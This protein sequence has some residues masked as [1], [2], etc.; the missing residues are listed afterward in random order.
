[1]SKRSGR[2]P[3]FPSTNGSL[4]KYGAEDALRVCRSLNAKKL[5]RFAS[6][7]QADDRLGLI[8][9]P[10]LWLDLEDAAALLEKS[11]AQTV[12]YVKK[13][14][15][16]A[17]GARR[18]GYGILASSVMLCKAY[19]N[20][21]AGLREAALGCKWLQNKAERERPKAA[22]AELEPIFISLMKGNGSER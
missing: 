8:L 22:M 3:K 16:V 14:F 19:V 13:G 15:L 2:R 7:V 9:Q 10:P 11:P 1:M 18:A 5:G 6:A 21:R 12:R 17:R 4:P 20:L